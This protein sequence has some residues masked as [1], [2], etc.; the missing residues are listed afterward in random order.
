MNVLLAAGPESTTLFTI[1]VQASGRPAARLAG[2]RHITVSLNRLQ[3]TYR[4]LLLAGDTI[5]SVTR[6]Q[7]TGDPPPSPRPVPGTA[8]DV[9]W[10]PE[11]PSTTQTSH[12]TVPHA[13]AMALPTL[14][15][16]STKNPPQA[17]TAETSVGDDMMVLLLSVL[18]ALILLTLQVMH[19]LAQQW[20][21]R[22]QPQQ[23][24]GPPIV[25]IRKRELANC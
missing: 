22:S 9:L 8:P 6:C 19:H 18:G 15:D 4:R 20:E 23:R 2:Q 5:L 13:E 1:T 7:H 10:V 3:P 11:A 25:E 16:H 17:Q 12:L 24:P 21:T 14:M